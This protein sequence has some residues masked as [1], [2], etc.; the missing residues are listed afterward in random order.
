MSIKSFL[1]HYF[2]KLIKKKKK[3]CFKFGIKILFN[4]TLKKNTKIDNMQMINCT[5]KSVKEETKKIL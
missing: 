2:Y 5:K 1:M 3:K 4:L